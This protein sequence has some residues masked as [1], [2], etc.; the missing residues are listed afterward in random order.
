MRPFFFFLAPVILLPFGIWEGKKNIK[1]SKKIEAWRFANVSEEY[2]SSTIFSPR[3]WN[4][5]VRMSLGLSNLTQTEGQ[6]FRRAYGRLGIFRWIEGNTYYIHGEDKRISGRTGRSCKLTER[7]T[8][9][10]DTC[11]K[12]K[13]IIRIRECDEDE[14]R[15]VR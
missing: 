15:S 13:H 3:S 9:P 2:D 11:G 8:I 5:K 7:R 14:K 1:N 4:V 6:M 10:F 12:Y